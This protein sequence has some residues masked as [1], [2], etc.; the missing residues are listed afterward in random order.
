V[1]SFMNHDHVIAQVV[2]IQRWTRDRNAVFLIMLCARSRS[3]SSV[4]CFRYH[5]RLDRYVVNQLCEVSQ[6]RG[7]K[8][9]ALYRV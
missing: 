3:F 8:D 1:P 4:G 7:R 9:F 6:S 2:Q 5:M